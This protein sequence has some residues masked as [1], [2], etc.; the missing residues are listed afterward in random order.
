MHSDQFDR[1]RDIT[2]TDPL[3]LPMAAGN[4]SGQDRRLWFVIAGLTAAAA[5]GALTNLFGPF[6]TGSHGF[7]GGCAGGGLGLILVFVT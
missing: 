1:A 5:A 2:A 3:L 6:L 7:A 4:R